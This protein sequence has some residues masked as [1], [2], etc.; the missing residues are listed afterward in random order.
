M[1][2]LI[3]GAIAILLVLL[4]IS[5]YLVV[6]KNIFIEQVRIKSVEAMWFTIQAE[7]ETDI[8]KSISLFNTAQ[9]LKNEIK[10]ITNDNPA[11]ANIEFYETSESVKEE[12]QELSLGELLKQYEEKYKVAEIYKKYNQGNN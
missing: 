5:I 7:N 1:F 12:I 4:A 2:E 6:R 8:E 3:Y 11:V 10:A 9:A